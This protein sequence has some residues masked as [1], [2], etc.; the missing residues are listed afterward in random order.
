MRGRLPVRRVGN[1]ASRVGNSE[2]LEL[3]QET[4][5]NGE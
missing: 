2:Y 1:R 5:F 3:M 4:H